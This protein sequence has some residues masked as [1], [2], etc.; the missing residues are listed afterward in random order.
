MG[1]APYPSNL[2]SDR[3]L[4]KNTMWNLLGLGAPLLAA[5]FAIPLLIQGMG[6]ARFG[7]LTLAWVVIG[8]FSFFD[9]G[10]G[11]A[12]TYSV[13][14]K[15]GVGHSNEI[16]PLIWTALALLLLLGL[17]GA[18]AG[19][20][21][22]PS[23]VY[24][25]L[26]VPQELQEESLI[27]F[28]LLSVSVPIVISTA[29][30]RGILE[31]YQRFGILNAIRAPMGIFSFVGPLAVLPFSAKLHFIVAVL[32]AVRVL[33]LF[34]HLLVCFRLI[35]N[36]RQGFGLRRAVVKPL[37]IFGGWITVSNVISPMMVYFD[38][39]LIGVVMSTTAVAYYATPH[40]MVTRLSV[41]P[42]AMVG[43]LFPAFATSL[44]QDRDRTAFL[45]TRG[46]NY[47]FF[48][49]F[50]LLLLVVTFA[51]EG[52]ALWLGA[53]FARR[54]TL[55]LQLLAIGVLLNSL[56]RFPHALVQ[57]AG[58]PDLTAKLH[59]AEAVFYFPLL[60]WLTGEYGIMGTAI[61]WTGRHLVDGVFLFL[62]AWR[63]L[64]TSTASIRRM[65]LMSGAAVLMMLIATQLSHLVGKGLFLLLTLLSFALVTWFKILVPDDRKWV[66][67][68]LKTT[69][70]SV[71]PR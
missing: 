68:W 70:H 16:P 52:M 19:L 13:A 34:A 65:A 11:R 51:R 15:L 53:E 33:A 63:L 40:E 61:A 55:V 20:L 23:L 4:A 64:P 29:G 36:L 8:Y 26:N 38:R 44:K 35:P 69:S 43:V 30:L 6:T 14:E 12:L 67:K 57:G 71:N 60:W 49:M 32:V 45:F 59:L 56:S 2:T 50:P 58:R 7:L 27:S 10:I 22:T 3:L 47:I 5:I 41:I 28:Y 39:F 24:H 62:V 25:W 37:I 54:S 1:N 46:I 9:L 42:V 21:L 17:V 66:R 18:S 31:S 48:V